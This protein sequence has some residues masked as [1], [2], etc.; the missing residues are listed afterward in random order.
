MNRQSGAILPFCLVFL[1]LLGLM[2]VAGLESLLLHERML[3]NARR[4]H[5]GLQAAEAALRAGEAEIDRQCPGFSANAVPPPDGAV[6]R[7]VIELT[8]QWWENRGIEASF[9]GAVSPAPRY[10]VEFWRGNAAA[11]GGPAPLY[12]RVTARASARTP[13]TAS[14]LQVLGAATCNGGQTVTRQRLSWRRLG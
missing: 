4:S 10:F 13:A 9:A 14:V 6:W 3:A 5:D 1:A 11:P 7:Q 2:A 12:Y 8:P